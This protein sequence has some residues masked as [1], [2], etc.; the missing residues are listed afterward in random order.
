METSNFRLDIK[1][2]SDTTGVYLTY[3]PE[4]RFKNT[5]ILKMLG[6]DRL[7]NKYNA[8]PNGYFDFVEGYTI[9]RTTGRVFLPAAEPFGGY[10][11]KVI[12]NDAIANKYTF[13]ELYDSTSTVAKQII[14][15]DKFILTGQYKA[16]TAGTISLGAINVPRGS[17]VV[18]AGGNTLTENSDYT[19]NYSTGEVTIINQ[20]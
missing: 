13:Q 14:E 8:H 20:I 3:L 9:N 5:T 4:E 16:T 1:Y 18:T 17:V 2:L 10:L 7:D 15:K 6:L 12:G 19:V 11:R